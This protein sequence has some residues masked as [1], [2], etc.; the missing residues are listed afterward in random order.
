MQGPTQHNVRLLGV[1]STVWERSWQ[2]HVYQTLL[3]TD[4]LGRG[5]GRNVPKRGWL[6]VGN[7]LESNEVDFKMDA[8]PD[9]EP[10]CL[11]DAG[12]H[13]GFGYRMDSIQR[14]LSHNACKRVLYSLQL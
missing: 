7:G 5:P 10:N 6:L 9:R 12:V 8:G 14:G 1:K 3:Q 2:K 13:V 4:A 11:R